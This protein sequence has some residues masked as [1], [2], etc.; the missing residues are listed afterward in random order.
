MTQRIVTSIV[1]MVFDR[2][3]TDHVKRIKGPKDLYQAL[4]H[5]LLRSALNTKEKLWVRI[6]FSST[7]TS[8]TSLAVLNS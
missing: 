7:M 5:I 6:C 1:A 8:M 3:M 2:I 4:K